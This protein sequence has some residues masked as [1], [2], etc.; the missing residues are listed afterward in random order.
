MSRSKPQRI[1]IEYS[2]GSKRE[3]PFD[4]LPTSLRI[5]IQR[6]S[7]ASLPSPNPE[8]EKFL[9]L[10]WEDG[11]REV[12]LVD[13][14]CTDINRYY[15]ISRAEDVGRLSLNKQDDYPELIEILRRPLSLT[16]ITFLDTFYLTLKRSDREGKKTDHFFELSKGGDALSNA[17]ND[18][19]EV[20][21]EE[22][23]DLK[24]L[25]SKDPGQP[26]ELYEKLRRKM[27]IKASHRQQDVHDFI[28]YLAKSSDV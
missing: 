7:F 21:E 3:S 23:I 17:L 2:D 24:K 14:S 6:Q 12:I 4:A 19:K 10:E 20:V 15:V 5:D 25:R 27:G 13:P 26:R 22:G 11:W 9:L 16:K 1:V 28:A 18:F 8:Q